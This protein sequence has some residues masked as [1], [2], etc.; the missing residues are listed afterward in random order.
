MVLAKRAGE[1]VR[2][3]ADF[4]EVR[5]DETGEIDHYK[6]QKIFTFQPRYMYEPSANR[7]QR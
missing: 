4:I 7:V 6:L 3:T 5:A 2:V 1:V